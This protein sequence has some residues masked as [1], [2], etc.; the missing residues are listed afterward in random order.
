MEVKNI[1]FDFDGVILNSHKTKT[2][3]FEKIFSKYGKSIGKKAKKYHLKNAGKSR[4]LKF[5]YIINNILKYKS[6]KKNM[7]YLDKEFSNYCDSKILK[8]E[9]SKNL[10]QY[11]KKNYKNK[12]FFISTGTPQKKIE[13]IIKK[14]KIKKFFKK[15]YGSPLKKIA[16]INKIISKYKNKSKTIF[17]G[18]SEEDYKSAKICGIDFLL[19]LNSESKNLNL[20]KKVNKFRS[21]KFIEKNF[22]I[23]NLYN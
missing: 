18:D 2:D 11:L 15:I 8:L 9:I 23:K 21:F 6:S 17:I 22:L 14:K 3:A 10:M 20:P 19:K 16:H 4:Y 13:E 7:E 5:K 12:N 1:I